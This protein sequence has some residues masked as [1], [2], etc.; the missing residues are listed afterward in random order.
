[1]AY[2][3]S[4]RVPVLL[5]TL[6][7]S[8]CASNG[9]VAAPASAEQ[10]K[11][12]VAGTVLYRERIAL[13]PGST[14]TVRLEDA[15]LMDA[16]AKLLAEQTIKPEGQVPVPFQLQVSRGS[17]DPHARPSLRATITGPDGQMLFTTMTHEAVDLSQDT[18]DRMLVLQRVGPNAA[19]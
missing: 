9:E 6:T 16:P 4:L 12:N 19:K 18:V 7:L 14:V 5:A 3:A 13:P 1:M 17:V 8:A 10:G 11:V 2:F 15:A